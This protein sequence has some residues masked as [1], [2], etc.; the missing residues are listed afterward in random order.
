[1]I[2]EV[3]VN[4]E[5]L[6]PLIRILISKVFEFSDCISDNRA[7]ITLYHYDDCAGIAVIIELVRVTHMIEQHEII[8]SFKRIRSLK[9]SAHGDQADELIK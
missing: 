6:G 5:K 4:H 9:S 3:R 1:M 2:L 8:D 7:S